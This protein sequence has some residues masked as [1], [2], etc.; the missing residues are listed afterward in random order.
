RPVSRRQNKHSLYPHSGFQM[1]SL[2]RF[3]RELVTRRVVYNEK[4]ENRSQRSQRADS[5]RLP[6]AIGMRLVFF[7]QQQR[8]A[9]PSPFPALPD[10]RAP[11]YTGSPRRRERRALLHTRQVHAGAAASAGIPQDLQRRAWTAKCVRRR[12][13]P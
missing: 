13:S 5:S 10:S 1:A 7:V 11:P 8:H 4:E 6:K 9:P 2:R 12:R 3:F